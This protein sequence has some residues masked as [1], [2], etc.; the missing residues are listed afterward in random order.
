[1]QLLSGWE[2]IFDGI[3]RALQLILSGNPDVFRITFLS[4]SVSGTATL[5]GAAIGIPIGAAIALRRFPGKTALMSIINTFMGLPPVVV[6][7]F[8]YL[9]LSGFGPLGFLHLLYTPEAMIMAQL[10]MVTPITAGI[11]LS[12]VSNVDAKLRETAI[13]IGADPFQEAW[14]I[15][16]EA[17]LGLLT[18]VLTGFGSAISEVGA[19]MVVGGNLL[20]YTRTLT[21]A[22][23]L[24]TNQGDFEGAIALGI[25]L[26]GLAF[27]VNI[28]L[29]YL[30]TKTKA[31]LFAADSERPSLRLK[32]EEGT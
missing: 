14:I 24:L 8:L 19:I 31:G 12:V 29:T 4:L 7:L 17:R 10:I 28:V 6:G 21:T 23:V 15:L 1:V 26:L 25:I 2:E 27:S 16:N 5:L 18:A 3:F 13:S 32:G 30:Q 20:G 22:V 9:I 11:T